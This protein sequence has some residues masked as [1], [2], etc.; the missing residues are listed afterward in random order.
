MTLPIIHHLANADPGQRARTLVS[1]GH[2]DD[3]EV[4]RAALD[5]TGSVVYARSAVERLVAQAKQAI[6]NLP[7]SAA[8]VMLVTMADAMAGRTH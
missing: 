4:V 5:S 1:L 8:K 2:G 3:V 6:D 7:D